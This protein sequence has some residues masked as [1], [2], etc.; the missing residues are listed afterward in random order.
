MRSRFSKKLIAVLLSASFSFAIL[1]MAVHID[2]AY[3]SVDGIEYTIEEDCAV[4]KGCEYFETDIVIP[5]TIEGCP[6]KRIGPR[7]F[8]SHY[9]LVS[10]TLPD[11]VE[12][13]GSDAFEDCRNL[14]RIVIPESVTSIFSDAFYGCE[15]LCEIT[16]PSDLDFIG[17]NAFYGTAYW[18]NRSNWTDGSLYMGNYLIDLDEYLEGEYTVKAGT[19]LIGGNAFQ[20]SRLS[21]VIIPESVVSIGGS[22]FEDCKSL[23]SVNL[24]NSIT[25]IGDSAF[26]GCGVESIRIPEKISEISSFMFYGSTIKSITISKGVKSIGFRAFSGCSKLESITVEAGNSVYH[27]TDNCLIE[28]KSKTLVLGCKNSVIPSDGSVTVIGEESFSDSFGLESIVIPEGVTQILHTAFIGCGRLEAITLPESL[29]SIGYWDLCYIDTVY[30][31]GGPHQWKK[32]YSPGEGAITYDKIVFGKDCVHVYSNDC[33]SICDVCKE[34]RDVNGHVYDNGCDKSCNECGAVREVQGHNYA[35]K[36]GNVCSVC[37]YERKIKPSKA[38]T[39]ASGKTES[40]PETE[41]VTDTASGNK[42]DKS[43]GSYRVLIAAVLGGT[44]IIVMIVGAV[45]VS[46]KESN[47]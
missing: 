41:V 19:K 27:S 18:N 4:I 46:K 24:P 9:N 21:S 40:T 16:L 15:S 23:K 1:T 26:A 39:T 31:N 44:S 13:I 12:S 17:G 22:A 30:Y 37:G 5:D 25:Y 34:Q 33:D 36:N 29:E 38:E 32:I 10:V 45:A 35:D 47:A 3:D 20:G 43:E 42:T 11:T 8:N 28:T 14:E 6:V 7:A 2:A